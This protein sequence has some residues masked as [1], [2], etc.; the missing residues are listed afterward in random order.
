MK[1]NQD[2][3]VCNYFSPEVF[4]PK[5]TNIYQ[6]NGLNRINVETAMV[7]DVVCFSGI[8]N[9]TIGQ[10][11]C[12]PLKV[13]P[14]NFVKISEPTLQ[15]VFSVN[16]SPSRKE[17]KFVTSRHPRA[18]LYKELLKDVS[19]KVEDGDATDSFSGFGKGRNPPFDI[20]R[21]HAARRLR[22]SGIDAPRHKQ[23]YRRQ[24]LR[25]YGEADCRSPRLGG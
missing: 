3:V 17:G 23:D 18:R 7:G 15:M 8:E 14:L 16:D 19:L 6:F 1:A 12:S 21:E 22:V 13:E 5:I 25:A 20:N 9:V 10:T 24:A 4:N 2:V 11:I